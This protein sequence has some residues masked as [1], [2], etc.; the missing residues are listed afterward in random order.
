VLV[1]SYEHT[2]I[3]MA[4]RA[5]H[6]PGRFNVLADANSR[7]NHCLLFRELPGAE[8]ARH[9]IYPELEMLLIWEQPDWTS[10][11]WARLFS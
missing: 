7:N 6:V 5:I 2:I 10:A 8:Y 3:I 11:L 4:L 1:F 9:P